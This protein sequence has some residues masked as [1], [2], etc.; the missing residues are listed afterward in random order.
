MQAAEELALAYV[1]LVRLRAV[2]VYDIEGSSATNFGKNGRWPGWGGNIMNEQRNCDHWANLLHNS[3]LQQTGDSVEQAGWDLKV[4]WD[5]LKAGDVLLGP[6]WKHNFVSITFDPNNTGARE[7]DFILDPWKRA[8]PDVYSYD[9]FR[10][11][12]PIA[13]SRTEELGE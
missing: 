1:N 12:W 10:W 6:F 5:A 7:P 8:R 11:L 9:E 2:D 13:S 4:H 3:L